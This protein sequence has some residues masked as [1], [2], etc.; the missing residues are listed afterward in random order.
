MDYEFWIRAVAQGIKFRYVKKPFARAYF[1]QDN[2][3]LGQRGNSYEQVCEM[4]FDHFG[5]VNHIWLQRYAEFLA[6][7]FDG[8]I[9]HPGNT[10]IEDKTKYELTYIKLLRRFDINAISLEKLSERSSERGLRHIQSF[11]FSAS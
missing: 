5:Y 9:A 10:D 2:K 3:T 4:L 6:E 7:G 1:H 11:K 8:V